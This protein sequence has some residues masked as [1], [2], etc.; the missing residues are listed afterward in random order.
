MAANI[1]FF[2]IPGGVQVFSLEGRRSENIA[3]GSSST[4]ST[5]VSEAGNYAR[6]T[7]DTACYVTGGINATAVL[8]DTQLEAGHVLD[9][10]PLAAGISFAVIAK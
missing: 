9:V 4:R 6:I 5:L 8:G 3:V 2:K 10:G 7:T 1:T